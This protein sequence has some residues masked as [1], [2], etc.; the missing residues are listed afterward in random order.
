MRGPWDEPDDG[1]LDDTE[2]T[3][4]RL[5]LGEQFTFEFDFGDGWMHLCTA[6]D[7]KVD[8]HEVYGEAPERPVPYWGGVGSPTSTGGGGTATTARRQFRRHRTLH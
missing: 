7:E 1:D 2:T 8:L 5:Q 3:L 4:S 6:A